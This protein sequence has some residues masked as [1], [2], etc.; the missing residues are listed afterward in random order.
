[1][2]DFFKF[3][4][5]FETTLVRSAPAEIIFDPTKVEFFSGPRSF[6]VPVQVSSIL[7]KGTDF[8][9]GRDVTLSLPSDYR[10]IS[11]TV[12]TKES[13]P[14][15]VAKKYCEDQGQQQH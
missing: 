5:I 15:V 3:I 1:M 14:Y 13:D 4:S 11:I 2:S 6:K 12:R 10:Y 8:P 9:I 7:P